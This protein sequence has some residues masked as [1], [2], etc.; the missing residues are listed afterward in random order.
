[1]CLCVCMFLR[2][3]IY[4]IQQNVR[5]VPLCPPVLR[6]VFRPENLFITAKSS[7]SRGTPV[8]PGTFRLAT[9]SRKEPPGD[10]TAR[11]RGLHRELMELH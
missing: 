1:M 5:G 6:N 4:F 10:A 2:V 11:G 8:P 7:D 9:T 3:G